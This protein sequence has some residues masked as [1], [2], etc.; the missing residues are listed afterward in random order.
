MKC[1]SILAGAEES[2]ALLGANTVF[3]V[4]FS[5][6]MFPFKQKTKPKKPQQCKR[7]INVKNPNMKSK[8]GIMIWV[9][10]E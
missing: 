9:L 1:F 2:F 5:K 7:L 3:Q 4:E 6:A 10:P 8:P